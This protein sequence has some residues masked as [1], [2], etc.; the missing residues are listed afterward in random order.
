MGIVDDEIDDDERKHLVCQPFRWPQRCAGAIQTALPDVACLGLL[1][2]PL[3][4]AIGQL[5]APYCP[6]GHQDDSKQNID[7]KCTHFAGRFDGRGG[8]TVRYRAH[9]P[10]EEVLGFPKSC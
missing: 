2:K 3:D 4:A 6:G 7:E 5:F 1:R 10:M 9:R 8:A